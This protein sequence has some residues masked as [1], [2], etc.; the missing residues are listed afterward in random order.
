M[1]N[2]S[3]GESMNVS[4]FKRFTSA[5]IKK[6]S[7]SNSKIIQISASNKSL[8]YCKSQYT[9]NAANTTTPAPSDRRLQQQWSQR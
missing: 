1:E 6:E 8:D 3:I 4:K 7:K 5:L 2:K 9:D